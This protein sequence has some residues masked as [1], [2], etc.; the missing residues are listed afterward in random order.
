MNSRGPREPLPSIVSV[1][2]PRRAASSAS[3]V[4]TE[5]KA[6]MAS[7]ADLENLITVPTVRVLEARPTLFS[8][9]E[10]EAGETDLAP[11]EGKTRI[12][13]FRSPLSRGA[14]SANSDQLGWKLDVDGGN[15]K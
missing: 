12:S 9:R 11:H 13:F 7:P 2:F 8:A 5:P 15:A 10:E 3:S 6:I 1:R 14:V 4:P